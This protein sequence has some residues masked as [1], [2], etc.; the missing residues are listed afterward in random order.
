MNLVEGEY[1]AGL[2]LVAGTHVGDIYD[3]ASFDVTAAPTPPP[4]PPYAPAQ[5]GY[6]ELESGPVRTSIDSVKETSR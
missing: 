2:Y 3:L 4:V 1:T 5:R 6:V